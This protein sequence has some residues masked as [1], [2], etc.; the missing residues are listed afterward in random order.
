M[1]LYLSGV[2]HCRP[3]LEISV[4]EFNKCTNRTKRTTR[5][6]KTSLVYDYNTYVNALLPNTLFQV[7]TSLH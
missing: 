2:P 7:Q 4:L 5:E 1:C 3:V 6:H